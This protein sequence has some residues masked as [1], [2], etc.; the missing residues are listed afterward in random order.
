MRTRLECVDFPERTPEWRAQLRAAEEAADQARGEM[1]AFGDPDQLARA[2]RRAVDVIREHAFSVRPRST[3]A[4]AE[5]APDIAF[6][7][8]GPLLITAGALNRMSVRNPLG[9]ASAQAGH[10]ADKG[11]QKAAPDGDPEM[12]ESVFDPLG[13]SLSQVALGKFPGDGSP[14]DR[15]IDDLRDRKQPDQD[16]DQLEALP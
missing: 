5:D 15:K 11:S 4:W 14:P 6:A 12:T 13:Y 1:R 16:R 2:L 10:D 7:E 9:D 8:A 3:E